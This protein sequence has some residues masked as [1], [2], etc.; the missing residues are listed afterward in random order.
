MLETTKIRHTLRNLLRPWGPCPYHLPPRNRSPCTPPD[1]QANLSLTPSLD[2]L[3]FGQAPTLPLLWNCHRPYAPPGA[4]KNTTHVAKFAPSLG[5]VPLPPTPPEPK[6]LHPPPSPCP[7]SLTP[8]PPSHPQANFPDPFPWNQGPWSTPPSTRPAPVGFPPTPQGILQKKTF[9]FFLYVLETTKIRHMLRN[10]LRPWGP[11]PYHLPPC[12][13]SPCT[14]PDRQ[15]NPSLTPSLNLLPLL[16]N[17]HRPY[18]PPNPLLQPRPLVYPAGTP[19]PPPHVSTTYP[20]GTEALAPPPEPLPRLAFSWKKG[21]WSTP[22]STRPAPV[23][24]YPPATPQGILQK[25]PFF[26][27]LYALETTKIRHTLRNLLRPWGPCLYHLPPRNRSPCTPPEPL[28]RLPD[29]PST[30]PGYP[31]SLALPLPPTPE[32]KPLDPPAPSPCPAK[33]L[34]L[35]SGG[36]DT[37]PLRKDCEKAKTP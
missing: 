4:D 34:L 3:L 26:F 5:P 22:A 30:K 35:S 23:G 11:C 28:P 1:R 15:A 16:W 6:P 31:P 37:T 17:C 24:G 33:R 9:F 10:L 19:P 14:P 8:H 36:P 2:L 27:F 32:P 12:N 21:A 20:P 18:A 13:R 29:P 25:Q 7:A